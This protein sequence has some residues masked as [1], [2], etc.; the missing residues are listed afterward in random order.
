MSKPMR[1]ASFGSG[2][3]PRGLR[4]RASR[5]NLTSPK[6]QRI[7]AS[8]KRIKSGVL[9]VE[10]RW[11]SLPQCCRTEGDAPAATATLLDCFPRFSIGVAYPRRCL[12]CLLAVAERLMQKAGSL[13]HLNAAVR[14]SAY[15]NQNHTDIA[16]ATSTSDPL[17]KIH[18][19][20][21]LIRK[22]RNPC[23]GFSDK[24]ASLSGIFG[25]G[26]YFAEDPEKID[27][28]LHQP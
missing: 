1:S 15:Q 27:Q 11:G 19:R 5:F 21:T 17:T 6:P 9:V 16:T 4:N 3:A 23:A 25:A 7:S 26:S 13:V 22:P 28:C 2:S 8:L 14:W 24:L 18:S 12:R 10:G 20:H